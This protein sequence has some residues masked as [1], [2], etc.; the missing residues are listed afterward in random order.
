MHQP[1][2]LNKAKSLSQTSVKSSSSGGA[3]LV[4]NA[5]PSSS[6]PIKSPSNSSSPA[7]GSSNK[8]GGG[9]A[10]CQVL[11]SLTVCGRV[12]TE[13]REARG[14]PRKAQ[15]YKFLNNRSSDYLN[16][17]PYPGNV[18]V[19][20]LSTPPPP[21]QLILTNSRNQH[22]LIN[23]FTPPID[24]STL[25]TFKVSNFFFHFIYPYNFSE[26]L[27]ILLTYNFIS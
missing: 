6:S 4:R 1:V 24:T 21:P 5:S 25:K 15:P 17:T 7:H 8:G 19:I 10:V 20:N 26:Y 9:G 14:M 3:V 18:S 22:H 16:M 23:N 12:N 2:P 13:Q 27:N 11:R